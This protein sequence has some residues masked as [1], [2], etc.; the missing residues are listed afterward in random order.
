MKAIELEPWNPEGYVGLGM[1]YRLEGM[2]MKATK[3]F[4]KALEYDADHET[5]LKELESLTGGQK[6]KGLKGLFST[7]LFGSKK[8]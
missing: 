8:K 3:Q 2:T 6:K 7:S 5:A 1:L 4:Q